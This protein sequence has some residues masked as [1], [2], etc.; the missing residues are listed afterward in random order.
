MLSDALAYKDFANEK[1]R[2]L[3]KISVMVYE[4][5]AQAGNRLCIKTLED[6]A[7][8][9]SPGEEKFRKGIL[10]GAKMTERMCAKIGIKDD[11]LLYSYLGAL[12]SRIGLLGIPFS[13]RQ[14]VGELNNKD[15]HT[16]QQY[17][18][19]SRDFLDSIELL[20]PAHTI[21]YCWNEN[22]DGTG[23][24]LGLAGTK[25]PRVAR[26]FAIVDAW[27][28]MT[29][30]WLGR[31]IPSDKEVAMRLREMAGSRFDPQLVEEFIQ[32]LSDDDAAV[33]QNNA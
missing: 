2:A 24:P 18:V 1:D 21:P 5:F 22:W 13:I 9:F 30:P 31:R 33:A 10:R 28:E 26:V 19:I 14:N 15:L 8:S 12:F 6:I 16:Y 23:F 17:P 7:V 3:D 32:A 25:I 27:N 29:R 11:D 4:R 20:R